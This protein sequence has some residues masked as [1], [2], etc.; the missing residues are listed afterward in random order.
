MPLMH[1]KSQKAFGHNVGAEMNAGKP[2]AQALAIAYSIKRKKKMAEGGM[3]KKDSDMWGGHDPYK[4]IPANE[5]KKPFGEFNMDSIKNIAKNIVQKKYAKGGMVD[6]DDAEYM[7]AE[8][9]WHDENFLSDEE[10]D[11]AMDQT[12]P[13]PD[14][15]EDT[16]GMGER[17]PEDKKMVLRRIMARLRK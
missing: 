5:P 15:V 13:D 2:K 7:E 3:V 4:T 14:G 10:Q 9:E 6:H 1:G 8:P 12:Y 17:E 11:Y 16:E